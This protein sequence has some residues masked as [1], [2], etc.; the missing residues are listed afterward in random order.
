MGLPPNEVTYSLRRILTWMQP[1]RHRGTSNN[2]GTQ[3][4][5]PNQ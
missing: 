2:G 3:K 5:A 1:K 4:A